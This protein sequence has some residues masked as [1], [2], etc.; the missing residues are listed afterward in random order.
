[1]AGMTTKLAQPRLAF[2]AL[3]PFRIVRAFP[4]NFYYFSYYDQIASYRASLQHGAIGLGSL[5][6]SL[7]AVHG[8]E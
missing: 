2:S 8:A 6:F 5:H 3:F 1:M 4:K 7:D